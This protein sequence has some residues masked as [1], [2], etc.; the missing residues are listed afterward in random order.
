MTKEEIIRYWV[1]SSDM[2][3]AAMDSLFANGHYVWTLFVGHLVIEKL[4]KALYVKRVDAQVP[5]SHNLL[6]IAEKTGI[7]L[8]TEQKLLM[9]EITGFNIRARYPDV[10]QRFYKKATRAFAEDRLR[11]I[12]ELRVWLME[13][14]KG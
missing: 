14:I 8:S 9:D 3:F 11:R 10:K 1:E 7:D 13:K 12:Q 4:L 5:R 2:D 6:A